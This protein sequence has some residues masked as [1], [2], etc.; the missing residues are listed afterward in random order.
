MRLI[1]GT[2]LFV[3]TV[4]LSAGLYLVIRKPAQKRNDLDK[5]YSLSTQIADR[6]R[7]F[8]DYLFKLFG[9]KSEASINRQVA[10][11]TTPPA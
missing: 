6:A 7:Q 5:L 2:L 11:P 9:P 4:A 3:A 1:F 10:E 8:R